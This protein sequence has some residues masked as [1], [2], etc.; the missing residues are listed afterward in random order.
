MNTALDLRQ[1]FRHSQVNLFCVAQRPFL[2]CSTSR[3]AR[4]SEKSL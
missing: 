4:Q 3:V 1:D 2:E